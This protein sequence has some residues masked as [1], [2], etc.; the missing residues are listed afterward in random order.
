MKILGVKGSQK[1]QTEDSFMFIRKLLAMGGVLLSLTSL[2][3][4][5]LTKEDCRT[6]VGNSIDNAAKLGGTDADKMRWAQIAADECYKE[7]AAQSGGSS[8]S[9][10]STSSTLDQ[11]TIGMVIFGIILGGALWYMGVF[12]IIGLYFEKR[13]LERMSPEQRRVYFAERDHQ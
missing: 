9:R 2:N 3:V 5:A 6:R 1:Q 4:H 10:A 12:K 8:S 13:K 7:V 11:N